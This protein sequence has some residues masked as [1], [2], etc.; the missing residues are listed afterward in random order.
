[1]EADVRNGVDP[2]IRDRFL[3]HGEEA[4][5]DLDLLRLVVGEGEASFEACDRL[6]QTYGGLADLA[7]AAPSELARGLG[8]RRRRGLAV[9]AAF[10]VGRRIARWSPPRGARLRCGREVFEAYGARFRGLRKEVFH[11]IL[12][13]GKNRVLRDERVSEGTLTSSLV[14]PRE[15]YA[16]AIRESAAS[17]LVVHNHPSGDPTPSPEDREVTRRL[18]ASGELLGIRLLDHVVLGDEGY[19]SFLERGWM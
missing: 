2:T 13:D 14:H 3:A 7:R 4:C 1:V 17:I 16:P 6:L 19:V 18:R 11:A 12:L 9:A 15:V 5:S 10:A 8:P